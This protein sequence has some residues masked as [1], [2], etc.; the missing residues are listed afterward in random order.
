MKV[1]ND[2]WDSGTVNQD[3]IR[4]AVT[5]N[6]VEDSG[7]PMEVKAELILMKKDKIVE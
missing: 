3:A 4:A 5:L 7:I 1:I 2:S 6:A